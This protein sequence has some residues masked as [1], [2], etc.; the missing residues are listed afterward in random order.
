MKIIKTKKFVLVDNDTNL[1]IN[2]DNASGGYPYYTEDRPRLFE[3]E[4]ISKEYYRMFKNENW[5]LYEL[6][7]QLE[8]VI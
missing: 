4:E 6:T 1:F 5:V 2:S 3:S 8:K 7:Y